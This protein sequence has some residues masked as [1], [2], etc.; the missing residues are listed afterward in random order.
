MTPL[1]NFLIEDIANTQNV[2]IHVPGRLSKHTFIIRGLTLSEIT[3]ARRKAKSVNSDD[4]TKLDG[5]EVTRQM[6]IA[7][8]VNPNFKNSEFIEACGCRTPSEAIDK[9]LLAG[10]A[11]YISNEI[12]EASGYKDDDDELKEQAKN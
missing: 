12:M 7:G 1:Q 3:D 10:E 11:T 8:C 5:A 9:V 6:I 4:K 2:E